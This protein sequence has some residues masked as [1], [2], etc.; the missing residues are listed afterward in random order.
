MRDT[1]DCTSPKNHQHSCWKQEIMFEQTKVLSK[2]SQY[3]TRLHRESIEMH[4]HE[5]NFYKKGES[6]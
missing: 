6:L 1:A 2:T 5:N 4:K 3:Y